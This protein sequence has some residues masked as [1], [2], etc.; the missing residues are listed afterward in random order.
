MEDVNGLE[1]SNYTNLASKQYSS[2]CDL[3]GHNESVIAL[4]GGDQ[5]SKNK[6][7][8]LARMRVNQTVGGQFMPRGVHSASFQ[9]QKSWSTRQVSQPRILR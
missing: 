2:L 7:H 8:L 4:H 5:Q 9:L 3:L 1:S 6:T